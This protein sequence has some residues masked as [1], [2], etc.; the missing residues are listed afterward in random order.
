M[1]L[2]SMNKMGIFSSTKPRNAGD[3]TMT[4]LQLYTTDIMLD[5]DLACAIYN[6]HISCLILCTVVIEVY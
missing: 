4:Y 6:H 3:D 1:N 2:I 5:L